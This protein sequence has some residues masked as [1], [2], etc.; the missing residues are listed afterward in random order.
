MSDLK[1]NQ[2]AI[3]YEAKFYPV[4]KEEYRKKLLS[5]GAKLLRAERKMIRV[6]ADSK[7]N[8]IIPNMNYLRVRD[9]GHLIRLSY[10]TTAGNDG[11][12]SD[13][14]EIDV[15]VSD[16][17]KTVKIIEALG[18]KFNRR[19][20]TL[21][22]EWS[23]K[24]AEITIDTWPGLDTYSEIE[25]HSE[26]EVKEIAEELG[27]DWNKKVITAAAEIY[28]R[29]YKIDIEKVLEMITNISFENNS[30]EG[31]E[32]HELEYN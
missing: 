19:Q 18:I 4:D 3:E 11:K 5:V 7:V 29:V 28:E 20:E 24:G 10:N 23:Y 6:I 26:E 17:S 31:L 13:Q 8:A 2:D 25:A 21:R 22:E 14:K 16:F 32:K 1:L 30:F 15:D 12:L 27:F 9:E